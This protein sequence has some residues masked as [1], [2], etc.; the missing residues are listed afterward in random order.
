MFEFCVAFTSFIKGV[1]LCPAWS[2]IR[3]DTASRLP[4]CIRLS[5]ILCSEF[6]MLGGGGRMRVNWRES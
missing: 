3:P 2:D 4:F 6:D 5:S 1:V